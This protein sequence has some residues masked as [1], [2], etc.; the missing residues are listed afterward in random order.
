MNTS[1]ELR[2]QLLELVY[3]LLG[4]EETAELRRRIDT[5]P[6]VARQYAEVRDASRLL[7]E[8]AR[9]DA[10][11]VPLQA[12]T[13]ETAPK[14][15]AAAA[16]LPTTSVPT[17]VVTPASAVELAPMARGVNILIAVAASLLFLLSVGSYVY[18]QTELASAVDGHVRL[19]VTG[20][21]RLQANVE[22]QYMISTRATSGAPLPCPVEY[23]VSSP[24]GETLVRGKART[25]AEGKFLVKIPGDK[26]LS[27]NS[28]LEVWAL[29]GTRPEHLDTRLEVVDVHYATQLSLDKPLYQPGETMCYRSL[30]LARF[31]LSNLRDVIV[32][33]EILDPSGAIV[34]GSQVT[35]GTQH[36]VGSGA[37][38]IPEGLAGG[39]YTLVAK[40]PDAIFPDEKRKFFIRQYR[41]PRLKKELEFVR[42]SYAPGDKVVA[43]FSANRAEGGPAAAATLK[44]IATVDE[45]TVFEADAK[46]SDGGTHQV[47][48]TL[49]KEIAKG[50]GQLLVIIDDGGTR[51]TM[52]KTIP[53]NLGKVDV[54]FYPEGGELIAGLP[55]RVYFTGRDPLGKAVHVEGQILDNQGRE[56]ATVTTRHEGLGSFAFT[57]EKDTSY[58]LKITKP[59]GIISQPLL[60]MP[61][62]KAKVLLSA[63][64][65]SRGVY[66]A[67]DPLELEVSATQANLPLVVAAYC[68]GVQVGQQTVQTEKGKSQKLSLPLAAEAGG[69]IRVTVFDYSAQPPKPVA[70][71][72]VY[73]RL[74][75]RLQIRVADH[76]EGYSPGEKV[77]VSLMVT[78][79]RGQPVPA[80]LGVAVVD[81]TLLNLADDKTPRMPTHFLLTT[82]I[83]KP[84]DLEKADFFLSDGI[85]NG[86]TSAE[87][88]DLLLGTQGWRRFVERTLEE[89]QQEGKENESI[90]RLA[91]LG[92]ETTPPAVWDNLPEMK[93]E[94]QEELKAVA[95]ASSPFMSLVSM[96]GGIG[97]LL[98]LGMLVALR[99][100]PSVRIWLPAALAASVCLILGT[101]GLPGDD[102]R[103]PLG[104]A[105]A[106]FS[107]EPPPMVV[108]MS[109]PMS[110]PMEDFAAAVPAAEMDVRAFAAPE[111][112]E[113]AAGADPAA[114]PRPTPPMAMAPMKKLLDKQDAHGEAK[115][116]GFGDF[117]RGVAARAGRAQGPGAPMARQKVAAKEMMEQADFDGVHKLRRERFAQGGKGREAL[118]LLEQEQVA[119]QRFTIR[120]YAHQHV[121]PTE[122]GLRSDFTE[123][124]YWHP[125]LIA[126]EEGRAR[127]SFDL[128]DAVTTFQVLADGH[129]TSSTLGRIGSGTGEII[130]RIPF[131][132]QPKLP[133][134]VN[135]GDRIDLP[136]A[137]VNDTRSEL[138]VSLALTHNKLLTLDGD[139]QRLLT[140]APQERARQFFSLAVTGEAGQAD[141]EFRGLAGDL[142][143]GVKRSIRVVPPGFPKHESYG[144]QLNGEQELT[145]RLPKDW[146]PG[147]L[148]VTLQAFPSTLADLQKGMESILREPH[149]CFEQASTSNYPN[150]LTMQYM[151]E[152]KVANPEITKRAKDLLDRGYSK[153]IGYE[154]KEKGYEW[155]GGAAP[156]HEALTAYG[157]MEFRDMAQVHHVDPQM[158]QR[159]ADWLLKRRDGKGGFQRNPRALDSFGGAPAD[160]TDAYIVWALS[161]SGQKG[162]ETEIKHVGELGAKSDDPYLIALAAG[163]VLNAGEKSEGDALLK[164]LAKAQAEDGH[165][166][167]K[168]GSITRSGGYSLTVETTSLAVLAW[169]KDPA[170]S[171]NAKKGVEW[172]IKNRQGGGFGSTQGTILALKALVAQAKA[173]RKTTSA[174]ELVLKRNDEVIG[175]QPFHAG[176]ENTIS[177]EG[178]AAQLK[179]G[180][181]EVKIVLSG[182]NQMPYALN[183]SYRSRTP[184]SHPDCP[185]KLE[186]KL[187]RDQVKA[188]ETV[189]LS[190]TL[191]NTTDKGQ[192]M[193][194]AILGLPAGLEPRIDQLEKL[195]KEGLFDYFEVNA[196]EV[197][198]YW[199]AL[200][201]SKK[202]DIKL[203]LVAEIPGKYVGPASRAYLYYTA[204]QKQWVEPVSVE[205]G[206]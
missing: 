125:M 165:L 188:G 12:P 24:T 42:D 162:I 21:A 3:D 146:V 38:V 97:L 15:V 86:V 48:F 156:G 52:A 26:P 46:S 102:G 81:S 60:Q 7:A 58:M 45:A 170:Y 157:L 140:L 120:Q 178:I 2:Q 145:I 4:E 113:P 180:E 57:P 98:G 105:F 119:Q 183:V 179:P 77:N 177:V 138:A 28:R 66:G 181:N 123:T 39:E 43:N 73:R 103:G 198:C 84:Q 163:S 92:G 192:P 1:N 65:K 164:K 50:D 174:G 10:P 206:K 76:S 151:E 37:F 74:D 115:G 30:T 36:G 49:P 168:Q 61:S 135:A 175:K 85:K 5:D 184:A 189:A 153:L 186:T 110:A 155:F 161:E 122:P 185:L 205:I 79:E 13:A 141:L 127:L 69:V 142:S 87:A 75:R 8:A 83:E 176:E 130:S 106:P 91:A 160:I 80:V 104:V 93:T 6:E 64:G 53:I 121:A 99:L 40:S 199:R 187:A 117:G 169:L 94:I 137:I 126:D 23:T 54:A 96:A 35:G 172:I 200:A 201:P 203:D 70:E 131:N 109:A 129:S 182:N 107:I 67:E 118:A 132:L 29:H 133:L 108:A 195:K 90:T 62:D 158:V 148:E 95:P 128:S 19:V 112:A 20:P 68:R 47:E 22:N 71:R 124:V 190:A 152:H 33:F 17:A 147:S 11:A 78:N 144:G 150:V 166:D 82:E 88:L 111:K 59:V 55:N 44:V 41:L 51:E 134:E 173:S 116:E 196:R 114:L 9:L 100:V 159:T 27:T 149:G 136:L 89:I 25:D 204:E 194:I 191:T 139:A 193:T 16:P 101:A 31:G 18:R 63:G 72:L 171:V 154:C 56:V 34:P 197:V 32:T 143:D 167:G 14:L 202:V